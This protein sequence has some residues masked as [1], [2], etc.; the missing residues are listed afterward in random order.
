MKIVILG[1]SG[2][3]ASCLCY[4]LKKDNKVTL[5]SRSNKKINFNYKNV[6]IKKGNYF[7]PKSLIKIFK[8]K[9]YIF[10]L[11]GAN[12]FASNKNKKKSFNLKKINSNNHRSCE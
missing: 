3:L 4:Y 7:S 12:S 10:H 9:D 2:Y 8:N 11:V 5:V 6:E 1:G